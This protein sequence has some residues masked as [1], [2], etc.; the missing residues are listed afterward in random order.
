MSNNIEKDIEIVEEKIKGLNIH[1]KNYEKIDCKTSI[2]QKIVEEK[3]ALENILNELNIVKTN[4]EILQGEMDRIGIDTLKLEKGSSTDDIIE[5]IK[6]KDKMIDSMAKVMTDGS[7]AKV[8]KIICKN[9]YE[10]KC[11]GKKVDEINC[12]ECIKEHFRKEAEKNE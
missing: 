9:R 2:Y 12:M 5:E 1:I 11:E 6:V 10:E 4:Y 3:Q 7:I 8:Y